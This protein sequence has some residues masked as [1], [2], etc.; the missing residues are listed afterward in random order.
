M[1]RLLACALA[2][3]LSATAAYSQT[4]VAPVSPHIDYHWH[5]VAYHRQ[6]AQLDDLVRLRQLE[7]ASLERQLAEWEPLDRFRTG[8]PVMVDVERTRLQLEYAKLDLKCLEQR[9][10]DLT[11]RRAQGW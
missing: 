11:R 6:V 7:I 1:L 10:F 9:A 3:T 5:Q 4:P 8:R 2:C